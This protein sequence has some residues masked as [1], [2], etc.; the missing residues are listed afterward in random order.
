MSGGGPGAG[1]RPRLRAGVSS[2]PG[3]PSGPGPFQLVPGARS[4]SSMRTTVARSRDCPVIRLGRH[5]RSRLGSSPWPKR[6]A[7]RAALA[8]A[9]FE[10]LLSPRDSELLHAAEGRRH[11]GTIPRGIA[12][13]NECGAGTTSP[14]SG[15]GIDRS[16]IHARSAVVRQRRL[17]RY[18]P[19][20]VSWLSENLPGDGCLRNGEGDLGIDDHL[21]EMLDALYP[22]RYIRDRLSLPSSKHQSA[23][24]HI[25]EPGRTI[26]PWLE[27]PLR[28]E[29]DGQFRTG[30]AVPARHPRP[31]APTVGR[32]AA[33]R[34]SGHAGWGERYH[35]LELGQ[36][37]TQVMVNAVA[38][39]Q[40]AGTVWAMLRCR[41]L[42]YRAGSRLPPP[43]R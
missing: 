4:A 34:G 12:P 41:G 1:R 17:L 28:A 22:N 42:A 20:T 14:G 35:A 15:T 37:G 11:R 6:P 9:A 26:H 8:V 38:E 16:A 40:V 27:L 29:D 10:D 2:A 3:S 18:R 23:V 30:L 5:R 24:F 7:C 21:G 19:H 13:G 31:R 36:P 43:A 25:T 33:W 32:P 39:G